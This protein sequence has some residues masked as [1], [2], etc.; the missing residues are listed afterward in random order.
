LFASSAAATPLVKSVLLPA[1]LVVAGGLMGG[2]VVWSTRPLSLPPA[3]VMAPAAVPPVAPPV[4]QPPAIE[5]VPALAA[6]AEA[7]RAAQAQNQLARETALL[8]E[9]TVALRTGDPRRGLRLLDTYQR[10]F[11]AGVLREEMRGARILARCQLADASQPAAGASA[12]EVARGF[13]R[14]Y[15]ASPLAPR[16]RKACETPLP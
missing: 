8:A 1:L 16:I 3:T 10:R 6:P 15:P 2:A 5:D 9:V 7:P 12:R 13:L 11:P 4:S 14:A